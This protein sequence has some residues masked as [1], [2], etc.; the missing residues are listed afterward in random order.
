MSSKSRQG[1]KK[2]GRKG[3]PVFSDTLPIPRDI[4][5]YII[6]EAP[7]ARLSDTHCEGKQEFM[8][9]TDGMHRH[10]RAEIMLRHIPSMFLEDSA[11]RLEDLVRISLVEPIEVGFA[12]SFS[13]PT[14][15]VMLVADDCTNETAKKQGIRVVE[16]TVSQI[17]VQGLLGAD[18][19]ID[20]SKVAPP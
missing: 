2:T 15:T 12:K 4:R 6:P 5:I 10:N 18:H 20:L 9:C 13:T 19:H 17:R 11:T 3:R 7:L 14:A 16:V 8:L 1:P